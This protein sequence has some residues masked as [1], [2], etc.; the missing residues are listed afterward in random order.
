MKHHFV[1]THG[2]G[3]DFIVLDHRDYPFTLTTEQIKILCDRQFGVG[4]DQL[5][6]LE[7]PKTSPADIFMRIYNSDGYEAGAC[8]NATRCLGA[9]LADEFQRDRCYVETISGILETNRVAS[10]LIQVN[11]GEPIFDWEHIPLAKSVDVLHLP[12]QHG[13]LNDPVAVSMGNPHMVF[14]VDD[15]MGLDVEHLGKTL[16]N[17]PL[18]PEK[19]N[20]QF[21]EVIDRKTIRIRIYERGAGVTMSS[22]TGASASVVAGVK[23]DL[24]DSRVRV[25][26]DGGILDIVYEKTV[27][28]TGPVGFAFQGT[29]D[30]ELFESACQSQTEPHTL[31]TPITKQRISSTN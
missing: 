21:V 24:L 14:F 25:H 18:Y 5:I 20:V 29:F 15:V 27:M 10:N 6:V 4:C 13:V 16:T 3:N 30:K 8:G 26:C 2:L 23:R 28:M 22:G 7:E 1:K 19:T 9:I 31:H 11:M 17:H 12:I